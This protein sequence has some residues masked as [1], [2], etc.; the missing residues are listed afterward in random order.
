MGTLAG[1]DNPSLSFEQACA[2]PFDWNFPSPTATP[3]HST[4]GSSSNVLHTPKSA[5]YHSHFHDAFATP[6]MPTFQT[7]QLAQLQAM[8]PLHRPQS[9]AETLRSSFIAQQ[10]ANAGR[11]VSAVQHPQPPMFQASPPSTWQPSMPAPMVDQNGQ[12]LPYDT[13]Q[14]QT[15]PPTR[16]TSA[17]KRTQQPEQQQIAFGTPSTIASRRF[18]SPQ[19]QAEE[20]HG[21]MAQQVPM[22]YPQIQ[23]SPDMQG[24]GNV[25][26]ATAPVQSQTRLLWDQTMN[27]PAPGMQPKLDD[28]FGCDGQGPGQMYSAPAETSRD[29]TFPFNTPAMTS[30][31]TQNPPSYATTGIDC[32]S[33]NSFAMPSGFLPHSTSVDPSLVYSSPAKPFT[34]PP[35]KAKSSR[36]SFLQ[37][38]RRRSSAAVGHARSETSSSGDTVYNRPTVSLRRSNTSGSLRHHAAHTPMRAEEALSRS[39]SVHLLPP[40]TASPLKRVGRTPLNSIS[41]SSRPKPRAS[42]R[43]EIDENG[44]ARTVTDRQDGSPNKALRERY[45]AL[46]DS[47]SSGDESDGSEQIPSRAASFSFT[48][49]QERT[50]KAARLEA[51]VEN[52]EGLSIPRSGS[53]SSMRVTPSKAAVAAAAQLRRQGSARKA[54]TRELQRRKSTLSSTTSTIDSCPFDMSM[55]DPQLSRPMERPAMQ[56]PNVNLSHRNSFA[57]T[58]ADSYF[59][60]FDQSVNS[61][62]QQQLAMSPIN[63]MSFYDS[64]SSVPTVDGVATRARRRL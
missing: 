47:D 23:F 38:S 39:H 56:Q 44:C 22:Q 36:E 8:T 52:L 45:P 48:R 33:L 29:P 37:E 59:M 41:E 30:F 42:V 28:P 35:Q 26:P 1:M 25:G 53:S 12:P 61:F 19:R 14:T 46:W 16:D 27:T 49:G 9:S 18:V 15:P 58:A 13:T 60:S 63:E 34:Q 3:T 50:S 32:S 6:Q 31:G 55:V 11:V 5:S 64:M 40:R 57:P 7:P 24:L 17:R 21:F 4:F 20:Q 10:Q 51:P 54:P 2:G 43:L 62:Q